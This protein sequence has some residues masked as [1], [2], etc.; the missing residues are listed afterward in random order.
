MLYFCVT[1]D[2]PTTVS[3]STAITHT[4]S[5]TPQP[6]IPTTA[7]PAPAAAT[8]AATTTAAPTQAPLVYKT[9][10]P[11]QSELKSISADL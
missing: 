4:T 7:A 2:C 9:V 5:L 1:A 10:T 6:I 11:C 3:Q 8:T